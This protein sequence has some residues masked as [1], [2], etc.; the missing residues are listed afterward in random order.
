MS[1][2]GP[3]PDAEQS[4]GPGQSESRE[5]EQPPSP[6]G[7]RRRLRALAAR[8]WSP[9]AIAHEAG[10]PAVVV[11][12]ELDG[13]EDLVPGFDALVAAVYDR[14]WDWDPPAGTRSERDAAR[15]AAERAVRSGW[16]PPMA[17][18]DDLIDL[19]GAR[20]ADGW[21]PRRKLYKRA[22]DIVEDAE[23]VREHGGY[24]QAGIGEV[25]M[26]LGIRADR[27][28]QSYRRAQRYAARD[29]ARR[30]AADAEREAEAG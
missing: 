15:A 12:R 14:L 4:R 5:P 30:A 22:V 29:A 28:D 10:I 8:A 27:L 25:A 17:W 23:F 16:A 2:P 13:H 21:R 18:D 20:P 9:E 1:A 19:P 24:R 7:T 26:R 11:R 6:A 3:G